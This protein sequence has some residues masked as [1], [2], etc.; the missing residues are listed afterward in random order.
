[1]YETLHDIGYLNLGYIDDS[2]LQGGT[3]S[4]WCE[5]VENTASLL[6]KL[7]FH[8]HPT[9]SVT[10]PTQKLTFLGFILDPINITVSPTEGKIQKTIKTCEKLHPMIYEVAEVIGIIVSNFPGAQYGPLHYR[11]LELDKT[12]ALARNK[13]NYKSHMQISNTSKAELTWWVENMRHVNREILHP[14]P[15][16]VIQTGASKNGRGAVLG[17][18]G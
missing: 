12:K 9:K 14:N 18:I 1:M 8:L 6:R 13:G 5:N 7:Q 11:A 17:R 15:Q 3:H 4:E 16:L 2:Y 10:N